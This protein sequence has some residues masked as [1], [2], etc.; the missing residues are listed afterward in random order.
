MRK[1]AVTLVASAAVVGSVATYEGYRGTAYQDVAGVWTI[2]FG[3]TGGVKRGEKTEPVRA[4][5]RLA[6]HIEGTAADV[7]ECLGDVPLHQYE[8]DAYVSFA[9]NVGVPAFCGSTLVRKLKAT[10]PDY[11]GACREILRWVHAGG[12]RQPGL[13]KRRADEYRQCMGGV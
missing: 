13:V 10:P 7:R 2:G 3:Q 8:F 6:G 1:A 12:E 11:A 9:Y 4:V 5:Q